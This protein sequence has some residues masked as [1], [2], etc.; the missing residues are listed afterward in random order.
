[1]EAFFDTVG[2]M[3]GKVVSYFPS[4]SEISDSGV[5]LQ[6]FFWAKRSEILSW[7]VRIVGSESNVTVAALGF[8]AVHVGLESFGLFSEGRNGSWLV[9][10]LASVRLGMVAYKFGASIYR[11]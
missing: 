11:L 10:S 1:M 9:M 3:I 4:I 5:C 8:L 7:S 6:V 2:I